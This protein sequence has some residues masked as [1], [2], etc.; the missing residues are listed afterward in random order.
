MLSLLGQW[1]TKSSSPDVTVQVVRIPVDG[2]P[3]HLLKLNTINIR[4]DCNVDCFLS[5][6][7]DFRLYWGFKEGWNWRDLG[8]FPVFKQSPPEL[9]GL[10]FCFRNFALDDRP[11][12]ESRIFRGDM[13]IAKTASWEWESGELMEKYDKDS[14]VIYEDILPAF[15]ESPLMGMA[16]ERLGRIHRNPASDGSWEDAL[17]WCTLP[18]GSPGPF[19]E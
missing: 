12:V 2:S 10:Y 8:T 3:P 11:L 1:W 18:M 7:P 4:P 14:F 5:R 13:F 6:I 19:A 15:L 17:K 9:N 16:S